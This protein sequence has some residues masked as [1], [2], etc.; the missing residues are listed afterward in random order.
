[1][2]RLVLFLDDNR[3]GRWANIRMDD[4]SPCWIGIAQTG[5]LVKRSKAGMFGR[6]LY[7]EKNLHRAAN[8]AM[9]LHEVFSDDLT[10]AEM[11]NPVLK[12]FTNAILHCSTI[13]EVERI[14]NETT[15]RQSEG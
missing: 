15:A 13:E 4:E 6:K 12:A 2:T 11:W 7:H 8:K 1:M 14:L 5:V 3:K 9:T 10:P